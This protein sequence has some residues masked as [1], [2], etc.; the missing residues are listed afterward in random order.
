MDTSRQKVEQAVT[1]E[2]S[3]KVVL[4]IV[5]EET[6]SLTGATS[7]SV[8]MLDRK[9]NELVFFTH[10]GV[11]ADHFEELRF[12]EDRGIT[13]DVVKTGKSACVNDPP[14]DPRWYSKIDLKSGVTTRN[15]MSCPLSFDGKVI[16]AID[17]LNKKGGFSETDLGTLE[18]F[19]QFAGDALGRS[20]RL[21]DE[22]KSGQY[23]ETKFQA[24]MSHLIKY[25]R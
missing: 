17:V 25:K 11:Q 19:C 22:L 16:G 2:Q 10:V 5:I 7:A 13:G 3:L 1:G 24:T 14:N 18:E 21:A 8:V 9:S 15:M 12:P 23:L 6:L 4:K 20:K